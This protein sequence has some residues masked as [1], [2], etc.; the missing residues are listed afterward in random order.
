M[1]QVTRDQVN[2][3]AAAI[4]ELEKKLLADGH[5][6]L[7]A[8]IN[9]QDKVPAPALTIKRKDGSVANTFVMGWHDW[10]RALERAKADE[11]PDFIVR[12][13]EDVQ[14]D[15]EEDEP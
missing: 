8:R 14:E 4:A 7:S 6:E 9:A 1:G 12:R 2:T 3:A 10:T 13:F 5:D 11:V 15:E